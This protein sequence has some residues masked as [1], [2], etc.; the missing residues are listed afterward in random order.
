[1]NGAKHYLSLRNWCNKE[2][3]GDFD[4]IP[5]IKNIDLLQTFKTIL[6]VGLSLVVLSYF[7]AWKTG[8]LERWESFLGF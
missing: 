7:L 2:L 3:N 5:K 4:N 1:M 8:L 6:S